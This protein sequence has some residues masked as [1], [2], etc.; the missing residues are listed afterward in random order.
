MLKV[1]KSLEEVLEL[2]FWENLNGFI[3]PA[4][5]KGQSLQNNTVERKVRGIS[6]FTMQYSG[7][8]SVVTC[9]IYSF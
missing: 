5:Q 3:A 1:K 8:S 2:I 7:F 9:Q 4:L 6:A